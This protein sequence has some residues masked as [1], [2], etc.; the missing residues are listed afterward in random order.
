M[1]QHNPHTIGQKINRSLTL[2]LMQKELLNLLELTKLYCPKAPFLFMSTN[3]VYSD[4]PN[5][6]PLVE[7]KKDGD[8]KIT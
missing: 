7:K 8:K 5:F 3:K 1:L 4:N 2:I 6:L